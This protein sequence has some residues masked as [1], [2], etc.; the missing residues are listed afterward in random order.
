MVRSVDAVDPNLAVIDELKQI[1]ASDSRRSSPGS[2]S[3]RKN[4]SAGEA[5][6]DSSRP[7]QPPDPSGFPGNAGRH[8]R[9]AGSGTSPEVAAAEFC[10]ASASARR[11]REQSAI[12]AAG[13]LHAEDPAGGWQWDGLGMRTAWSA[14]A[15]SSWP[16]KGRRPDRA[17]PA[18]RPLVARLVDA[19]GRRRAQPAVGPSPPPTVSVGLAGGRHAAQIAG[20]RQRF[21]SR[22]DGRS[23]ISL[24]PAGSR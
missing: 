6:G 7:R 3:A 23:S 9:D 15:S 8:S 4:A 21:Q 22:A 18:R 24:H 5:A 20:R 14:T 16:T 11:G 12:S 2:G 13:R 19:A 1:K 10:R 17:D